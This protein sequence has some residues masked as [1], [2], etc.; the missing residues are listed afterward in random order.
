M[1]EFRKAES[2]AT[3]VEFAM[4]ALPFFM[5]LL[6]II[7][8]GLLFFATQVLETGVE[9]AARLI[10]TGQAQGFS[11]AQFKTEVCNRIS[12]MFDCNK[13]YIDVRPYA[14]FAG[15]DLSKPIDPDTQNLETAG[16]T[17]NSGIGGDIVVVRAFYE[18]PMVASFLGDNL[19]D[20]AN[21]NRLLASTAAFRNEPF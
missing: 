13:L 6:A 16:F 5:L 7:E 12:S 8:I 1:N 21:G 4:V 11:E 2:G 18:W 15:V 14:Q 3:A 17:F 20:L 19:G 10:R 9:S